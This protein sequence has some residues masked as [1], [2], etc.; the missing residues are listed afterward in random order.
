[1]A[2]AL[3]EAVAPADA[4]P[5]GA[6]PAGGLPGVGGAVTRFL[7]PEGVGTL[8]AVEGVEAAEAL[9]GVARVRV[10]R[11]PG[12][13]IRPFRRGNDRVGA[14]LATGATRDEAVQRADRAAAAVRFVTSDDG[15][16]PA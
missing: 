15:P 5:A 12:S 4:Q 13:E 9:P 6:A 16:R 1:V 10:Y 2:A 14:V 3:G 11:A 7:V 8:A